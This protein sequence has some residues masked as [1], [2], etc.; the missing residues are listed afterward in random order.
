[1]YFPPWGTQ[2]GARASLTLGC[3][4]EPLTGFSVA[5]ERLT[6]RNRYKRL[7]AGVGV[8]GRLSQAKWQGRSPNEALNRRPTR[9][10]NLPGS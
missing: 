2:G 3:F 4:L 9:R 1:M 6:R 8:R 5:A 10:P 7:D